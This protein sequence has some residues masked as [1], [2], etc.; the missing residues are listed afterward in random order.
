M[1]NL[2]IKKLCTLVKASV[3]VILTLLVLPRLVSA[4][5]SSFPVDERVDETSVNSMVQHLRDLGEYQCASFATTVFQEEEI[6]IK[7]LGIHFSDIKLYQA[8]E[9]TVIAFI[10]L[11]E[12]SSTDVLV[13]ENSVTVHLP[14]PR[15]RWAE[16]HTHRNIHPENLPIGSAHD[17]A[18]LEDGLAEE[19]R[20][21]LCEQALENG[22][23]DRAKQ[24]LQNQ[25]SQ[26]ARIAGVEKTIL[27]EF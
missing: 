27:V 5:C 21:L 20:A 11:S 6:P 24:E 9:G 26:F 12:L 16:V 4:S 3:F 15:I 14:E 18:Q 2:I 17:M 25:A 23:M 22:I 13:D 7:F 10:D 19:A 8:A 1:L